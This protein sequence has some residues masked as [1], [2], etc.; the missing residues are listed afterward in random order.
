MIKVLYRVIEAASGQILIDDVDVSKL[1]L[2]TLRSRLSIIPQDSQCFEGTL[3]ENLDP[4]G[5]ANDAQL[6]AALEKCKLK[7]HVESMEGKLDAHIDE[8]GANLSAG[9]RQLMC[10]GV[11]SAQS[12]KSLHR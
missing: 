3:R 7:P 11:S 9:Q 2:H 10:L 12:L 1:G 6:W 4:T 8:G 5:T